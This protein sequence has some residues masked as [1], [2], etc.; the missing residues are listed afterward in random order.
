MRFPH[1]REHTNVMHR[2]SFQ[3]SCGRY[4][5]TEAMVGLDPLARRRSAVAQE[6]VTHGGRK[7]QPNQSMLGTM[8]SIPSGGGSHTSPGLDLNSAWLRATDVDRPK[9]RSESYAEPRRR[10]AAR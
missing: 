10:S 6:R 3:P 9:I 8:R 5:C 1:R 2:P 4:G 7:M